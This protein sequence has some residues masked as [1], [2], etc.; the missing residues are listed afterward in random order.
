MHLSDPSNFAHQWNADGTLD[1]ICLKCF[2]TVDRGNEE[3]DLDVSEYIH[4]C[5]LHVLTPLAS[6][7]Q[8]ALR[9]AA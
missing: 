4:A 1:S 6:V 9:T 8:R 5:D 2:I 3:E 7:G